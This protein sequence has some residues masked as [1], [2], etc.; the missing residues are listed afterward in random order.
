M[1]SSDE[2]KKPCVFANLSLVLLATALLLFAYGIFF[3]GGNAVLWIGVGL[4]FVAFPI[5]IFSLIRIYRN[6]EDLRGIIKAWVA[7]ITGLILFV[8]CLLGWFIYAN[9]ISFSDGGC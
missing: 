2:L 3:T 7:V 1:K 6:R 9:N 4:V 8:L 5:G